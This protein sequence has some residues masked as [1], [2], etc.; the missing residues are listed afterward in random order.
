MTLSCVKFSNMP[1]AKEKNMKESESINHPVLPLRDIVVF[2]HMIVR[3]FVG[4]EKSVRALE[5]VMKDDKEILLASQM[6]ASDDDPTIDTIYKTGVLAN[7]L[8]ILKLPD[9]AVKI[10]VEGKNRVLIEEFVDNE[11]YFQAKAKVI[12]ETFEN[13]DEVEALRRSVTEDFERYGKLNKNVPEE[14][15]AAILETQEADKLADT[16]AGHLGVAV[17]KK[18]T[19]MY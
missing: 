16:V 8:Q 1:Y 10:L 9:G 3:L 13:T 15:F 11:D 12:D 5:E 18:K 17:E 6:N 14:A 7:V 19:G 4:R 2:P